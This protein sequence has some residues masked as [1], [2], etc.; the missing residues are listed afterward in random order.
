[1]ATTCV[2]A[3]RKPYEITK[4]QILTTRVFEACI[5]WMNQ[6]PLRNPAL[7]LSTP[8]LVFPYEKQ[9]TKPNSAFDG[10]SESLESVE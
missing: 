3:Y 10:L 7:T 5:A 6:L 4:L 8:R 1:M 9:S 2:K